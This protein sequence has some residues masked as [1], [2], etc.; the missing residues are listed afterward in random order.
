MDQN[1][2]NK[3]EQPTKPLTSTQNHTSSPSIYP[4]NTIDEEH[5]TTSGERSQYLRRRRCMI[6][7]CGCCATVAILLGIVILI[8]SFTVFKIKDPSLTVNYINITS[9]DPGLGTN[10][11]LVSVNLTLNAN[12]SLKNPNIASFKFKNSTTEFFYEGQTVGVAYAPSGEVGAYKTTH[13]NV[14]LDVLTDRAVAAAGP[15]NLTGI[16]VGEDLNFTSYTDI[17]G[18]VNVLGVYKRNIDVTVNCTYTVEYS[19]TTFDTKK[20][21]CSADAA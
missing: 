15:I 2:T 9:V 18:R 20:I 11:N 3:E 4:I 8:L 7:C 19:V 10:N 21:T 16:V 14:S 12:L 5:G 6:C 13:M 17:A 1:Q